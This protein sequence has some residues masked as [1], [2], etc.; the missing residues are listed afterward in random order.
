MTTTDTAARPAHTPG[1]LNARLIAFVNSGMIGKPSTE[2]LMPP[3][4]DPVA[5]QLLD[6]WGR[7]NRHHPDKACA[8]C[9][10][11]FRPARATSTYCSRACSWA[12]NGG[13]NKKP[14]SWWISAKGYV[15]G[16][17]WKGD[18]RQHTKF[19]RLMME[20]HLGRAL[21]PDED[22]HHLNGDKADNRIENLQVISH[23]A[24]STLTN[25]ERHARAAIARAKGK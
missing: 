3:K 21:L 6:S 2:V 17:V 20:Q 5:G 15:Q 19:H 12:N 25:L 14:E 13:Q 8:E 1:P 24:H 10:K 16:R 4:S 22:V 9:G 23:G 7:R 18:A 11:L